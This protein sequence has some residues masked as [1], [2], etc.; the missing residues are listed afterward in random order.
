MNQQAM[1]GQRDRG[2]G[3][4][5]QSSGRITRMKVERFGTYN[6]GRRKSPGSVTKTNAMFSPRVNATT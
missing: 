4:A 3:K 1:G 6:V 5:V 2:P